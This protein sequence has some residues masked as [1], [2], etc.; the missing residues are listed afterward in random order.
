M[1]LYMVMEDFMCFTA[2]F[3][4][5]E[6][7]LE[8]AKAFLKKRYRAL[9]RRLGDD[10]KYRRVYEVTPAQFCNQE[11]ILGPE[12]FHCVYT[13]NEEDIKEAE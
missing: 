6:K 12:D 4:H 10:V 9:V 13:M 5:S 3:E 7:G 2:A 1:A 11:G 8:A